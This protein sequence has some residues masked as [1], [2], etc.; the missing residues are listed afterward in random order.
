MQA[1]LKLDVNE[2]QAWKIWFQA[3][4]KQGKYKEVLQLSIRYTEVVKAQQRK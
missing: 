1:A 3:L 4:K 2:Q